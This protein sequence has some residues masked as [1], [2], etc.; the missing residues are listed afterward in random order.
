MARALEHDVYDCVY[1]AVALEE[2]V[3]SMVTTDTDFERL[4]PAV[5]IGYENPV[6]REVLKRFSSYEATRSRA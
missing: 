4:C 6:P 1:L 5:G 3:S 2:N